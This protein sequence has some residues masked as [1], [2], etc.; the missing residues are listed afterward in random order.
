VTA[1]DF[2]IGVRICAKRLVLHGPPGAHAW[3]EGEEASLVRDERRSG[4]PARMEA[5]ERYSDVVI[6]KWIVGVTFA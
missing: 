2:E 1:P 4:V 3:T 5:G 6:D